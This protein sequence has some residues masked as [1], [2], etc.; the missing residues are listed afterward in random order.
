MI[1]RRVVLYV[2]L[3][4]LV[5]AS[6][7][8]QERWLRGEV[9]HIGGNGERLPEVNVTVIMN[10]RETEIRLIHAGAFVFSPTVFK[11]GEKVRLDVEKPGWRIQYPLMGICKSQTTQQKGWWKCALL[12]VGSMLFWTH[13]IATRKILFKNVAEQAKQTRHT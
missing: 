7:W 5:P 12:P 8:A 6:P 4:V 3:W 9:I 10:K 2:L 1:H 13:D 11:A